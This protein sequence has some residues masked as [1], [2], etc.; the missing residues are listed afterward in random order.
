MIV[1]MRYSG[2]KT[3][4]NTTITY[5]C[6]FSHFNACSTVPYYDTGT[7]SSEYCTL[8]TNASAGINSCSLSGIEFGKFHSKNII[9][10]GF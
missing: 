3:W 9:V 2:T 5:P 8:R 1:Y 4:G 7:S 6:A 10:V